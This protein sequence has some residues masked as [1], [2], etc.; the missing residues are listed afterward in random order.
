MD[1]LQPGRPRRHT[2]EEAMEAYEAVRSKIRKELEIAYVQERIRSK[3]LKTE[4][5]GIELNFYRPEEDCQENMS[6]LLSN[7]NEESIDYMH[8]SDEDESDEAENACDAEDSMPYNNDSGSTHTDAGEKCN[9]TDTEHGSHR[10][11]PKSSS[12]KKRISSFLNLEAEY[13]GE[14]EESDNEDEDAT[15]LEDL[16]DSAPNDSDS[17]AL[18]LFVKSKRSEDS[19]EL[20]ELESRFSEK[21]RRSNRAAPMRMQLEDSMESLSEMEE[22]DLERIEIN[23]GQG[24]SPGTEQRGMECVTEGDGRAKEEDGWFCD[25]AAA[26]ERLSK[27]NEKNRF[28]FM[29]K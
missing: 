4:S 8:S 25:N 18:D 9:Q 23:E 21:R 10:L 29:E 26:L 6:G 12:E 11:A 3:I 13:S 19:R 5:T 27:K 7:S 24:P 22:I 17:A 15:D 14:A 20:R 28:G 16:I 1:E 2:L